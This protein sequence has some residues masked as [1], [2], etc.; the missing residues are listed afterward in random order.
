MRSNVQ[1]QS[2]PSSLWEIKR[3]FC[4]FLT[5]I[6]S[7]RKHLVLWIH[8][9]YHRSLFILY[10]C[11]LHFLQWSSYY[12]CWLLH[13]DRNCEFSSILFKLLGNYQLCISGLIIGV[14]L[15][16]GHFHEAHEFVLQIG[17][18]LLKISASFV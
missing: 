8:N 18:D 15:C 5:S 12:W 11:N 10:S 4:S 2:P 3:H 14:L 6:R 9:G 16:N 17:E 13:I 1:T 7:Y